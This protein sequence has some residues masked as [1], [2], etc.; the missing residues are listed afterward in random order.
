MNK[1]NQVSTQSDQQE[2]KQ[3]RKDLIFVIV[4]NLIFLGLVLGLFFLNRATGQ[5]DQFFAR[6]LKF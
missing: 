4:L 3:V 1:F 2:N 5:V 6:L